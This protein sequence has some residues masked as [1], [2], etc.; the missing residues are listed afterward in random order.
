[1][2]PSSS[3]GRTRRASIVRPISRWTYVLALT[4]ACAHEKPAG[5]AK[6]AEKS[7][8][9][10]LAQEGGSGTRAKGEDSTPRPTAAAPAEAR[11]PADLAKPASPMTPPRSGVVG[12]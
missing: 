10:S 2:N 9:G 1:M 5:I 6:D 8:S 12:H 3:P 7:A 11:A 4:V